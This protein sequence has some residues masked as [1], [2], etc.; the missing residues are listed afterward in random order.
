VRVRERT[1]LLLVVATVSAVASHCFGWKLGE[2]ICHDAWIALIALLNPE[3]VAAAVKGVFGS[4][5]ED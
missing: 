4:K 2:Q 3:S 5:Q 1:Y